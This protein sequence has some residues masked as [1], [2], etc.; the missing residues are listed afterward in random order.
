M[1]NIVTI[2]FI[3]AGSILAGDLMLIASRA[4]SKVKPDWPT[5]VFAGAIGMLASEI[6]SIATWQFV[7]W[8]IPYTGQLAANWLSVVIP[9]VFAALIAA[10]IIRRKFKMPKRNA[11]LCA[12]AGLVPAFLLYSF[13]LGVFT[14][15]LSGL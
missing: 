12:L 6:I 11:Y 10:G 15:F 4:G 13:L 14:S 7:A 8:V 2:L 9:P 3:T 5:A 1:F